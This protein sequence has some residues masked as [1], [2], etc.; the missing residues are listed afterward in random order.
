MLSTGCLYIKA[1]FGAKRAANAYRRSEGV[2][3]H[4]HGVPDVRLE[5]SLV[6]MY[7]N[8]RPLKY[9][10][11]L[12]SI[13]NVSYSYGRPAIHTASLILYSATSRFAAYTDASPGWCRFR[14]SCRRWSRDMQLGG[15]LTQL[16]PISGAHCPE[17][18]AGRF[19]HWPIQGLCIAASPA[20]YYPV[21]SFPFLS[22]HV[23]KR[24]SGS[25]RC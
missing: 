1:L 24:I 18:R 16:V 10:L 22:T 7:A 23:S 2:I 12:K 11:E 14:S 13:G 4:F 8:I 9:V 6:N 17:P 3:L 20:E 15:P 19:L 21:C 5:I 25:P